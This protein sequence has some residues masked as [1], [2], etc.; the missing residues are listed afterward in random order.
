MFLVDLFIDLVMVSAF[1]IVVSAAITSVLH[2]R[3]ESRLKERELSLRE[4][5]I[6]LRE[7][8]QP[9]AAHRSF[10]RTAERRR[11]EPDTDSV[12]WRRRY[13]VGND[14]VLEEALGLRG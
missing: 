12:A 4:R 7:S 13:A 6:A 5:E 3:T 8:Y 14:D 9:D 11:R 2:Y 1:V 10:Q